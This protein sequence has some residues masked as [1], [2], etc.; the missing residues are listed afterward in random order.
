MGRIDP[1]LTLF[2]NG[3]NSERLAIM[4]VAVTRYVP[5]FTYQLKRKFPIEKK[6]VY[7]GKH[8]VT[9]ST[10]CDRIY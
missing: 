1:W 5:R 6:I 2:M 10:A 7:S 4:I 3:N 8:R 9:K